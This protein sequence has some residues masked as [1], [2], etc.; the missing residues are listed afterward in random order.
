LRRIAAGFG[1]LA[2]T[3]CAGA[4]GPIVEVALTSIPDQGRLRVMLGDEPVELRRQ[5]TEVSARSLLCTHMGCELQ[6]DESA[7]V[8]DCPCHEGSFA[9]DGRVLGGP[10]LE[11]LRDMAV[12]VD[13][14]RV[15]VTA[16]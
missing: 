2:L 12:R 9:A 8:Y 15:V 6:W 3:R 7:R 11:P 4:G 13:A 5:G 1:L 16:E 14:G 10:P